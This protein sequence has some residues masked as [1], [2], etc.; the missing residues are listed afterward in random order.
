MTTQP[1]RKK[2]GAAWLPLFDFIFLI[3][4]VSAD[5]KCGDGGDGGCDA[6]DGDGRAMKLHWMTTIGHCWPSR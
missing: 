6:G 3:L 4:S 1:I 2:G 5:P